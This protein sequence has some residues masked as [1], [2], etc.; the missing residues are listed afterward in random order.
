MDSLFSLVFPKYVNTSPS[1]TKPLPVAC[2][3]SSHLVFPMGILVGVGE[4]RG[5]ALGEGV[6]VFGGMDVKVA[7]GASGMLEHETS[8]SPVKRVIKNGLVMEKR[9]LE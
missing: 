8:S 6:I 9:L 2:S 7:A 3:D 4:G 1:V 5:V